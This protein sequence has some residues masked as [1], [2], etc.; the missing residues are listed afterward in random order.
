LFESDWFIHRHKHNQLLSL[1]Q[2]HLSCSE[3]TT[4]G[5]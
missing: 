5:S 4:V 3:E 2:N 1:H